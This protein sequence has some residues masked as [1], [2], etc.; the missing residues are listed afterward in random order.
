MSLYWLGNE[1][2]TDFPPAHTALD[3]PNGLLAAGGDLSEVRLLAA[4]QRGIFPWYSE[5]QPV[6]WWSPD[7]RTILEPSRFHTSRSLRKAL[8]RD[9]WHITYNQQFEQV[10][11]ACAA[12]RLDQDGTWITKDMVAAYAALHRAGWAHSIEV[13]LDDELVGGLYG[14]A[15]D[16]VF[17][18]ESMFSRIDNGSKIAMHY[19]CRQL[20]DDDFRL[21]DCQMHTPHLESLGAVDIPRAAFG[22]LIQRHCST[23][24]RWRAPSHQ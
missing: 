14:V 8:R 23:L 22:D 11:L 20:H 10:M 24:K 18:G 15:I 21:L 7:P 12:P 6:L 19:L 9:S 16:R 5:G 1:S 4:Y 17:F 13:H 2:G 3:D